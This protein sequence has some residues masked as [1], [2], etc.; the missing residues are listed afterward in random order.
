MKKLAIA[1]FLL[2]VPM[3]SWA[4]SIDL[5]LSNQTA[6][7]QYLF[8]E[9][10]LYPE[11]TSVKAG[12]SEL[13]LGLFFNENSENLVYGTLFARGYR[14]AA[15]TQY[16]VSAGMRLLGGNISIEDEEQ[17]RDEEES[18]GAL[19]LGFQAGLLLIPGKYNPVDITFEGFYAPSITSFSDAE[20]YG[21]VSVKLQVEIMPRARAYI[22][23]R[24]IRFDTNDYADITLDRSAHFGL[25][26]SF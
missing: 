1:A 12:G 24:R 15:G 17:G 9:D 2:I 25:N 19:A 10:V 11:Q 14:Q 26:L 23:Y 20:R 18:I 6:N 13:S 22:G 7:L 4:G 5:S 16:Q 21:Q 8:N 3:S